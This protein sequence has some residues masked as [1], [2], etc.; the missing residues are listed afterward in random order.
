MTSLARVVVEWNGWT[1]APGANVLHFSPGT[2]G[3]W[4][5]TAAQDL[6]D[7]ITDVYDA[8]KQVWFASITA[9]VQP[10]IRIIDDDSGELT[11]I[12]SA[13]TPPAAVAG[14][15]TV[16]PMS[17]ATQ[18]CVRLLTGEFVRGRQ[19][20]GRI[21]IGPLAPVAV[22]TEGLIAS[23]IEDY[24]QDAWVAPTSG[25]GPRLA[26]WSRPPGGGSTGGSYGDVTSVGVMPVPAVLRSRRD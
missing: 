5:A 4:D 25:T 21:F 15:A 6:V 9:T 17:R 8:M 1:G 22:S 2:I 13:A 20:R 12:F 16:N 10:T 18:L 7:E 26:V 3:S 23:T 24:I 14:T 19:L 11:G